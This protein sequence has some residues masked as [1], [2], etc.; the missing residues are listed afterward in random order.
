MI[1]ELLELDGKYLIII[2]IIEIDHG[3]PGICPSLS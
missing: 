1:M 3:A 2:I